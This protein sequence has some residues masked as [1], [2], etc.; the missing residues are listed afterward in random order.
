MIK[1]C[2]IDYGLGNVRSVK[3]AI[4]K[5]GVDVCISSNKKEIVNASHLILPGVGS[6]ESGMKG[7]TKNNLINILNEEVLQKQKPIGI[8][9]VIHTYP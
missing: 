4:I 1:I 5:L 2:I 8:G 3:N 9:E 7:L 6:F